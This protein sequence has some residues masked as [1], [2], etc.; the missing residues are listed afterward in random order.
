[1]TNVTILNFY[2]TSIEKV[3]NTP[4]YIFLGMHVKSLGNPFWLKMMILKS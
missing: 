3:L 4:V 1:M 2:V